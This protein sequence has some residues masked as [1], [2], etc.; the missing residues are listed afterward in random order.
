[1]PRGTK[2]ATWPPPGRRLRAGPR[3]RPALAG[4]SPPP[5]PPTG[6]QAQGVRRDV[7]AGPPASTLEHAHFHGSGW[8]PYR[9]RHPGRM[10]TARCSVRLARFG[11]R[12][13][14][15][16][17]TARDGLR[18]TTSRL[19]DSGERV[20][21][22]GSNP[23]ATR[24]TARCRVR[25]A[26]FGKK[27]QWSWW[28]FGA[29]SRAGKSGR[30]GRVNG[31]I[32]HRRRSYRLY[33]EAVISMEY[34]RGPL[35]D[36]QEPIILPYTRACAAA[37]NASILPAARHAARGICTCLRSDST[38][39]PARR[40]ARAEL[41]ARTRLEPFAMFAGPTFDRHQV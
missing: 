15:P 27:G 30:Q 10:T 1:M 39:H 36:I 9:A 23:H 14:T 19:D 3:F 12:S 6:P 5:P 38:R 21:R 13:S 33:H 24:T 8:G 7:G 41:K 34:M 20:V 17:F 37:L 25:L 26:R 18:S 29:K 35:L 2:I 40:R 11:I 22:A 28:M 4:E 16:V 31:D 32:A